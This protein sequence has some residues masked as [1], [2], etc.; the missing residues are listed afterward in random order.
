MKQ[1]AYGK[2]REKPKL[3]TCTVIVGNSAVYHE[4][5]GLMDLPFVHDEGVA[6]GGCS[7][8]GERTMCVA[9]EKIGIVPVTTKTKL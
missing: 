5:E 2:L 9:L 8:G 4:T 7:L 3:A 1:L 6:F